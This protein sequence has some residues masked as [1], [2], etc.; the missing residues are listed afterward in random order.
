MF[1]PLRQRQFRT[2][3][4][5]VPAHSEAAWYSP[6]HLAVVAPRPIILPKPCWRGS[7]HSAPPL[8]EWLIINIIP[9]HHLF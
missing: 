2:A 1:L 5:L 8:P 4:A 6:R 7:V 3:C 9:I